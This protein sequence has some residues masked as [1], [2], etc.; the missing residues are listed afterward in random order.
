[1]ELTVLASKSSWTQQQDE[2]LQCEEVLDVSDISQP[3]TLQLQRLVIKGDIKMTRV[4]GNDNC[5]DLG[6]KQLDY[7][8]MNGHLQLC[9]IRFAEGQSQIALQLEFFST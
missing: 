5:A 4:G 3:P 6:T 9:G 2:P 8:T 1:M 7:Q